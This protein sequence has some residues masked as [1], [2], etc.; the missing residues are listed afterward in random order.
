ME[1]SSPAFNHFEEMPVKY[2]C[3]GDNISPPLVIEDVPESAQSLVL[4]VEDPDSPSGTFMHWLVWNI[5]PSVAEVPEGRS[6][7][8]G[9]EGINDSNTS[10]YYGP[11][12]PSGTHRYFFR[13][14]ALDKLLELS[15]DT[16]AEDLKHA[17]EGRVVDETE[18][19]GLFTRKKRLVAE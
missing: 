15:P 3:L 17:M 1:I 9:I 18:L 19:V 10:G 14:Y 5:S 2:S 6:P 16:Q 13:L 7:S 11:C 4:V 12:P 8:G